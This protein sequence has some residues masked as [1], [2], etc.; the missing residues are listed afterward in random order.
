MARGI[1]VPRAGIE[2]A[3]PALEEPILTN[4]TARKVPYICIKHIIGIL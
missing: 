4:W 2:A 3:S 1:L